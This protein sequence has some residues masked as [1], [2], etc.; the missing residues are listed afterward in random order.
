M[1]TCFKSLWRCISSPT[2][3]SVLT[4]FALTFFG[5]PL[6]VLSINTCNLFGCYLMKLGA[7]YRYGLRFGSASL[8]TLP[9]A[10]RCVSLFLRM[11]EK[12]TNMTARDRL[13]QPIHQVR[14]STVFELASEECDQ[15]TFRSGARTSPESKSIQLECPV[16]DFFSFGVACSSVGDGSRNISSAAARES[17]VIDLSGMSTLPRGY[18]SRHILNSLNITAGKPHT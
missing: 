14:Q 4:G 8:M 3:Q 1:I 10:S 12:R 18:C 9:L 5:L 16:S 7:H 11:Q 13:L 17:W 15:Y 6:R 2:S